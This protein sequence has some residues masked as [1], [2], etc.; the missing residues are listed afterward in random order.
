M[1]ETI[2][3][4]PQDAPHP[5]EKFRHYKGDH[6]EVVDVALHANNYEW[7]VVYKPLSPEAL[8]SLFTR[9]LHEWSERVELEGVFMKRFTPIDI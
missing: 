7:M 9:P 5:G 4:L 2:V 1:Q 3:P 6:Y 8:A